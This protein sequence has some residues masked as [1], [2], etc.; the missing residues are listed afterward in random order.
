MW[1]VLNKW[2]SISLPVIRLSIFFLMCVSQGICLFHRSCQIYLPKGCIDFQ[3]NVTVVRECILNG[4][5]PLKL[6]ETCFMA[7][8]MAYFDEC[9]VWTSKEY[10][11]VVGCVF[12]VYQLGQFTYSLFQSSVS[13]LIFVIGKNSISISLN[14]FY[15]EVLLVFNE[16][17]YF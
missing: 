8:L 5:N 1:E 12:Y 9:S 16:I 11:A 7:Q 14:F 2:D 17:S 4:S 15:Y 10:S 6:S 3:F 13:F